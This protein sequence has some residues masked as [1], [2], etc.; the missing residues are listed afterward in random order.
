MKF[1]PLPLERAQ[2]KILGHNIAGPDG[3]RALRKGKPLTAEDVSA[4]R[5]MGRAAVYAAELEP[6]DVA[7]DAAARRVAQLAMGRGLRPSGP[8]SGRVNLLA[9]SLGI[10]RVD[11]ERLARVNDCD[12]VT[13]ATLATYT[14]VR[15][16]QI[17]ATVK[18]IP[19][20]I[21]D[22]ILQLVESIGGP[23]VR[24]DALTPKTVTLILSGSPSARERVMADFDAPLRGRIESLGSTV[25]A[26][27]YVPL[28]D[29]RGEAALA[30]S[31]ARHSAAGMG[32]IV[33]A[34]ETA[35][36]DRH[37][38]APRAIERAGGEVTCLG[39]PVD[40]GNL[41]MVGYVQAMPVLGAPGCARS[42][43]VNVVDWVLPRLLVG[44]RLTRKDVMAL[45]H[46][47]LLDEIPER[48]MPRGRTADE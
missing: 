17:A 33:L 20:A 45:G 27:E 14:V 26:V 2:G 38:I 46:G 9:E 31:L 5:A 22:S 37:D 15:H 3:K 41:L 8:A 6:G 35:I 21:P 42:R 25:T 23:L 1:G 13:V 4:L 39:A 7:E 34:G 43:K 32:L 36:M 19:F 44:D 24:V 12:G 18:I 11:A 10:V 40:P 47:G 48:P 28:E 30:E 16:R 29:E